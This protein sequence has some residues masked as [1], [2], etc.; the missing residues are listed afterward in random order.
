MSFRGKSCSV[1]VGVLV[2]VGAL[3]APASSLASESQQQLMESSHPKIVVITPATGAIDSV[4]AVS[5]AELQEE[6]EARGEVAETSSVKPLITKANVCNTGN[7]CYYAA[8]APYPNFGFYGSKG[9]Y[10]STMEHRGGFSTGEYH[11]LLA[12][13][14]GA[15]KLGRLKQT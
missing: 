8:S 13:S 15:A 11:L 6:E 7:G 5:A 12:G 4:R 10:H 1:C 2:A 14:G 3:A 9:T